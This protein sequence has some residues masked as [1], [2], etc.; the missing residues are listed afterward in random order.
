MMGL[1]QYFF[2]LIY[3]VKINRDGEDHMQWIPN[4]GGSFEV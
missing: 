3:S 2:V 1:L 4:W